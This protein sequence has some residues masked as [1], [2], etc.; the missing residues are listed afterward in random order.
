MKKALLYSASALAMFGFASCSNDLNEPNAVPDGTE[1]AVSFDLNLPS[2]L[3][4]R[5][6]E[7]G[8]GTSCNQLYY[9][10]FESETQKLVKSEQITAFNGG[11]TDKVTFSLI[12]GRKY[13]FVFFASNT[14]ANNVYSINADG[15]GVSVNYGNMKANVETNDA[16]FNQE[17]GLKITSGMTQSVKLYRPFAQ[18]N[19]GTTAADLAN[20]A[21]A[22]FTLDKTSVTVPV[23]S[24]FSLTDG[25]LIGNAEE[26][27][28]ASNVITGIP[29]D[30]PVS[31]YDYIGLNYLL[32][33]DRELVMV[34]FSASTAA[35]D[36]QEFSYGNVPVQRN[37]RTNIYGNL[38]TT[39]FD[40][41]IEIVPDFEQPDFN[42]ERIVSTPEGFVA[43]LT[44]PNVEKVVVPADL[45]LTAVDPADLTFATAKEIQVADG[46]TVTLPSEGVLI[47]E[48]GLTLTGKGTLTNESVA[49]TEADA[50]AG[51]TY[52]QL[53]RV[54]GGELVIDGMTLINDMDYHKHGNGSAGY[55]Y[56]SAAV[57]YYNDANVT[58]KN[59][60]IKSGEFTLCGMGRDVASGE[61]VLDNSYFE[62]TSSSQNG[63]NNWSYAIRMFGS[64]G[65]VTDCTVVGI[66]GG[67]SVDSHMECT[68]TGGTFT[69]HN[70][71]GKTDA[72][73][74]LYITNG[75]IVTVEGGE[76]A[77]AV[78]RSP[79]AQGKSA[80][81]SGDNDTGL[82]NGGAIIKGGKFS[83]LPYNHVTNTLIEAPE[84]YE[85]VANTGA[86]KDTYP[87]IAQKK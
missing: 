35:G 43:A 40:Y 67:L 83:G 54:M 85:I 30:F 81:V 52:R 73:Y 27:T 7:T 28:F 53:I 70:T 36:T 62:S 21:A 37:Y 84:G 34:Q 1:V 12:S 59:A 9:A 47:A 26:K 72:F 32:V 22:G 33:N 80:I 56:N 51:K 45:D 14:A 44:D 79:L 77:G 63:T 31:G 13:D 15:K 64:Q 23:Y 38:L 6:V 18:L 49:D 2:D 11:L 69:T 3:G 8:T 17:L 42:N 60:T 65:T 25:S 66:Q 10:V 50:A 58:I 76:F 61:I 86:D 19:I 46:A 87:W 71:P 78:E 75:A 68:I 39:T 74:P 55:P 5:A 41:N 48:Q 4:T 16:F 29:G 20:S 24:G 82:P 57:S